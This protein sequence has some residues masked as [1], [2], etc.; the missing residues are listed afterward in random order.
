[1]AVPVLS[2]KSS[3]VLIRDS[4]S[5]NN[6]TY[7]RPPPPT[8]AQPPD[9]IKPPPKA[10][11]TQAADQKHNEGGQVTTDS[12]ASNE[13]SDESH[14][15][16]KPREKPPTAATAQQTDISRGAD[17][18]EPLT[19][20]NKSLTYLNLRLN[21]LDD[22]GG[23]ILCTYLHRSSFPETSNAAGNDSNENPNSDDYN[24]TLETLDLASN[25][26][27]I[28]TVKALSALLKKNGRALRE[29]DVSCNKLSD[30]M[31]AAT[32]PNAAAAISSSF[33]KGRKSSVAAR[34]GSAT[35]HSESRAGSA[36]TTSSKNSGNDANSGMGAAGMRRSVLV[37]GSQDM[38]G[39]ML[40]EAISQNKYI[41]NFDIR[42]TNISPEYAS[43]IQA[44]VRE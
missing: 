15:V 16:P 10:A 21:R 35:Q 32:G 43:A 42:M 9:A 20:N 33:N 30:A 8:V 27:G 6:D 23:A 13:A 38:V 31:P 41:T 3:Q 40:F 14:P 39:K 37:E 34:T 11:A 19:G 12:D 28:E 26:L 36:G 5:S 17:K 29:I 22:A 25:G 2:L 44:I 1:M 24:T 7:V 18:D 4:G